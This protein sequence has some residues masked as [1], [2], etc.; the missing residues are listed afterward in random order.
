MVDGYHYHLIT[1]EECRALLS[2]LGAYESRYQFIQVNIS[3]NDY[4]FKLTNSISYT[5]NYYHHIR[6]ENAISTLQELANYSNVINLLNVKDD[7]KATVRRL[8]EAKSALSA[9]QQAAIDYIVNNAL[10]VDEIT[11][12]LAGKTKRTIF[13]NL[14]FTKNSGEYIDEYERA[15]EA[16]EKY[17]DKIETLK[18]ACFMNYLI[19]SEGQFMEKEFRETLQRMGFKARRV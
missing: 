7:A 10:F 18:I 1:V 12:G 11:H 6:V 4:V 15:I 2:V 17:E 8:R 14:L 19:D 13:E 9:N 5:R 16:V 3:R